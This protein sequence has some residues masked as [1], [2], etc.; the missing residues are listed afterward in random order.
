MVWQ[1]VKQRIGA[2]IVGEA[3]NSS[4]LKLIAMSW[5]LEAGSWK[6]EAGSWKLEAGSIKMWVGCWAVKPEY[7]PGTFDAL[8]IR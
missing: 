7:G 1:G 2:R 5:K 6:L 3:G 4:K 8:W